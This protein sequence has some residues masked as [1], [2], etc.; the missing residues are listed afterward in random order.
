MWTRVAISLGCIPM[1]GISGSC[2][3]SYLTVGLFSKVAAPFYNLT[4][5]E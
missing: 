5:R 1:G 3:N 4:S 2:G